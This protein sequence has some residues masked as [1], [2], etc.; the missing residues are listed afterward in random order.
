MRRILIIVAHPDDEVLGC[1]GTIAKHSDLGDL[2]NVIF[3][4][5]G[6]NSRSDAGLIELEIRKTNAKAACKILGVNHISFGQFPDNKL[7]TLPLIEIVKYIE[8]AL[9]EFNPDI[10]Y[11]H[12]ALDLNIDHQI[13]NRAVI[14]ATRPQGNSSIK[15]ILSFEILSSTEWFFSELMPAFKP[16]WFEDI[17]KTLDRKIEAIEA[18][19][20]ELRDWPH[21]RSIQGIRHL[22]GFRGATIGVAAAESFMLLRHI[23]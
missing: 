9:T 4:A 11:T 6:V 2:V 20:G 10:I 7:D 17:S 8:T 5:D 22:A 21:P 18:Y 13:V 12:S 23:K 19:R 14:T 3:L 1:G 16:N 15:T